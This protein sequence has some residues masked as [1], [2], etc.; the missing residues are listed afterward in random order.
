MRWTLLAA[1]AVAVLS[2][3]GS[4]SYAGAGPRVELVAGSLALQNSHEG[5]A[6]FSADDIGPGHSASG[7]VTLSN[8]GTLPGTLS[9]TQSEPTGGPLAQ[10]LQL[11][12]RDLTG[13]TTVYSGPLTGM[14]TR[15]LGTLGAGTARVYEFTASLPASAGDAGQGDSTTV[16]YTWIATETTTPP[17]PPP[18]TGP[19]SGPDLRKPLRLRVRVPARQRVA[20]SGRLVAYAR[21]DQACRLQ[22]RARLLGAR[23]RL[24][25]WGRVRA[26]REKR[27]VL[28]LSRR[29]LK[30]LRRTGR[31]TA[32]KVTVTGRTRAGV[33]KTVTKRALIAPGILDRPDRAT[34]R[35]L[36]AYIDVNLRSAK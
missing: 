18:P 3:S 6:V 8:T 13:G 12:V 4:G 29:T 20:T 34:R 30:T 24:A 21:C 28:K 32:V 35:T 11:V 5:E 10:Q 23:T 25:R 14:G 17:P 27:L 1:A 33:R 16:S 26:G 2:L 9:L 7:T 22:G 19:G 36:T 31:T 15:S